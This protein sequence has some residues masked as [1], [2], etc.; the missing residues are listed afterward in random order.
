MAT[1]NERTVNPAGGGDYTTLAAWKTARV[2]SSFVDKIERAICYAGDAGPVSFY[3]CPTMDA[4]SRVEIVASPADRHQ[5]TWDN[6]KARATTTG[7]ICVYGAESSGRVIHVRG[8]LLRGARSAAQAI[9]QSL[10][11]FDCVCENT[12]YNYPIVDSASAYNSVAYDKTG[13]KGSSAFQASISGSFE[14]INCT[15]IGKASGFYS[16]F[17]NATAKNCAAQGNTDGFAGTFVSG[18]DYNA[19][20]LVSDAPG[21]HSVTGTVQFKDA[22]NKDFHLAATDTVARGAGVNLTSSG[23]TTDIDGETRPA[24]DAWDIGADQYTAAIAVGGWKS[25]VAN[26]LSA[27]GLN[28]APVQAH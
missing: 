22:A 1:I 13:S 21:A 15:A 27:A 5:G 12:T 7:N 11:L 3:P 24:T 8:M 19:S 26:A 14:W 4:T 18:S 23:I 28:A 20:D 16:G 6:T 17:S 2:A 10:Y 9:V 25:I